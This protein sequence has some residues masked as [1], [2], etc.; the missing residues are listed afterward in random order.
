MAKVQDLLKHYQQIVDI[1]R[2]AG[3]QKVLIFRGFT[4]KS[5]HDLNIL[6]MEYQAEK[7]DHPICRADIVDALTPLLGCTVCATDKQLMLPEFYE[8]LNSSNS[9]ELP[10]SLSDTQENMSQLLSSMQ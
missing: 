5:E 1:F 8:Q 10:L 3:V 9:F 7:Q 2:R 6:I 4:P